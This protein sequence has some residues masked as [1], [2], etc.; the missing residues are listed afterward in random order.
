[1]PGERHA[2]DLTEGQAER[3]RARLHVVRST[4]LGHLD[5]IMTLVSTRVTRKSVVNDE[6]V[7]CQAVAKHGHIISRCTDSI[8]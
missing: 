5:S 3:R 6:S 8:R 2:K 1:M 4:S 7:R